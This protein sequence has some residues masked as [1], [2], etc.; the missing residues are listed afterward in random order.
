MLGPLE[1]R[2][3][4]HRRV[5]LDYGPAPFGDRSLGLEHWIEDIVPKAVRAA[6]EEDS[7]GRPVQLVGWCLG[8]ILALLAQWADPTASSAE[9]PPHWSSAATS[10]QDSTST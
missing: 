2:R 10:S 7:G 4:G 6:S 9:R 8:E 1:P 3:R 5:S